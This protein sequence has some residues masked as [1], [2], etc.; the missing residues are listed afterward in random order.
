MI[1]SAILITDREFPEQ[2]DIQMQSAPGI[3]EGQ[4]SFTVGVISPNPQTFKEWVFLA[5]VR[6]LIAR[7]IIIGKEIK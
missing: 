2:L 3:A 4:Y 5:V 6:E 1:A 7:G